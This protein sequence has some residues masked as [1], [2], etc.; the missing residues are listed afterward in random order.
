M[1]LKKWIPEDRQERMIEFDFYKHVEERKPIFDD[2]KHLPFL[3]YLFY[4]MLPRGLEGRV[5]GENKE[6]GDQKSDQTDQKG[7]G[8]GKERERSN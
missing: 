3:I 8:G 5:E 6:R 2:D 4:G 1:K 7:K